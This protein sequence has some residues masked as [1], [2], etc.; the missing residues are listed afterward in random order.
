MG[1]LKTIIWLINVGNINEYEKKR[2]LYNAFINVHYA[3]GIVR[4]VKQIVTGKSPVLN[5]FIKIKHSKA[6]PLLDI[7]SL[8]LSQEHGFSIMA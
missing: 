5:H 6:F 2:K 8:S 3:H 1:K 4:F 7:I